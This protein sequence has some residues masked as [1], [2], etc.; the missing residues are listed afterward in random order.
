MKRY[1]RGLL[2]SLAVVVA[3]AALVVPAAA[4]ATVWKDGGTTVT[5]AFEMGLTGAQNYEVESS[6][7]G[8]Q[9]N[10]H[11]TLAFNGTSTTTISKFENKGCTT[12][13]TYVKCTVQTAEAIGL[14]WAVTLGTSTLTVTGMHLK[15]TFKAG[16]A[17]GEI[18]QSLNMTLTP[19]STTKIG[20]L[21]F[22]GTSGAYKQFGTFTVDSPTYGIG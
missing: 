8:V 4:S 13:G 21:D 11:I 16:C 12:F 19:D 17:K 14:P 6:A 9:C 15:H 2:G 10:E 5:K 20:S 22:F 18:N 1:R 7:G 3:L